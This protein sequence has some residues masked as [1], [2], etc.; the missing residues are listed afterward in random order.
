MQKNYCKYPSNM[1]KK[2]TVYWTLSF[3][4]FYFPCKHF[5]DTIS[6]VEIKSN[7]LFFFRFDFQI[8]TLSKNF[9]EQCQAAHHFSRSAYNKRKWLFCH[10]T[11]ITIYSINIAFNVNGNKYIVVGNLGPVNSNLDAIK[12]SKFAVIKSK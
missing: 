11:K 10:C 5:P 9:R 7:P 4:L 2:T 8:W 1:P 12:N 6:F 3:V